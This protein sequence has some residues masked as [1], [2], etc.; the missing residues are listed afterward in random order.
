[1]LILN[2]FLAYLLFDNYNYSH[3]P[4]CFSEADV[5]IT[6]YIPKPKQ[7]YI[8]GYWSHFNFSI[9][10]KAVYGYIELVDVDKSSSNY[11]ISLEY[12]DVDLSAAGGHAVSSLG[13]SS[14]IPHIEP[15]QY[16]EVLNTEQVCST[17]IVPMNYIADEDASVNATN[18]TLSSKNVT[19]TQVPYCRNITNVTYVVS[20]HE[21]QLWKGLSIDTPLQINGITPIMITRELCERFNFICVNVSHAQSASYVEVD[22]SNNVRCWNI[23]DYKECVGENT[24]EHFFQKLLDIYLIFM[25]LCNMIN[26]VSFDS[27]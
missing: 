26:L 18:I 3:F 11:H 13:L 20:G 14:V 10:L 25:N 8:R 6:R 2:A 12:S 27:D 1:M 15:V 17:K 9:D 5:N 22:T 23:S 7:V 19:R 4:F 24:V 16:R 21:E